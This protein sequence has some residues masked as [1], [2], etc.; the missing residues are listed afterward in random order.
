MKK[1]IPIISFAFI[2]SSCNQQQSTPKV[3][4]TVSTTQVQ[5]KALHSTKSYD[6]IAQP[7]QT[8]QLSFRISGQINQLDIHSG[9]YFKKNQSISQLDTRDYIINKQRN[10]ALYKQALADYKR[11]DTL[12]KQD[13]ISASTYEAAHAKYQ[14]TKTNFEDAQNK[15]IDTHLRAPFNGY[16]GSVYVDNYQYIRPTQAIVSLVET[17]R[18]LIETFVTENI[19]QQN[20]DSVTI[21]FDHAPQHRIRIPVLNISKSTTSN[22]I[23]YKLTAVLGNKAQ[24][25]LAGMSGQILINQNNNA[26]SV[27]CLP[28][29]AIC[30]HSQIGDFVWKTQGNKIIQQKITLGDFLENNTVAILD[31][32]NLNDSIATSGFK[33]LTN[34]QTIQIKK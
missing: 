13:N 7:Y 19:A 5:K 2:L 4:Q 18:L 10:E 28:Q 22:N 20:I 25:Y 29:S 1:I 16:I 31:G 3:I 12:Y 33:F 6:F 27:L 23:S 24:T 11:M 14:L 17:D 9:D 30:H 34:G 26:E 15:V 32:L 8:A 21:T